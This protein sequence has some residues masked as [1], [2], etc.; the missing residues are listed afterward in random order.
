MNSPIGHV[1]VT[2]HVSVPFYLM[3]SMGNL[4][5]FPYQQSPMISSSLLITTLSNKTVA[6]FGSFVLYAI[7]KVR[8]WKLHL[9]LVR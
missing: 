5:I 4:W 1:E 8:A 9:A 2:D 6:M 7:Y 3:Q